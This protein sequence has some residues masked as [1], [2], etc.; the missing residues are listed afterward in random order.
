[1]KT[2][3]KFIEHTKLDVYILQRDL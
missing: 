3:A 2:A 1:L